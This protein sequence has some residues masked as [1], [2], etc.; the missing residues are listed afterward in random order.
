MTFDT[1]TI[2]VFLPFVTAVLYGINYA[3]NG[4]VLQ[5]ISASTWMVCWCCSGLLLALALHLFSPQKV[6]FTPFL[7]RPVLWCALA[8][9]AAGLLAWMFYIFVVKNMSGTYA[10]IGE[11]SYPFFTALFTYLFFHTR[12]IDLSTA[13]GGALILVGSF[14]VIA[15]NLNPH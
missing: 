14:I 5:A 4:R 15:D 11:V 3:M 6:D 13:V 1:R 7:E 10:A 9:I 2:A 8:S 12:Q